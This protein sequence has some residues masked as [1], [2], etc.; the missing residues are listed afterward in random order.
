QM[1]T[2][3]I[4]E[5]KAT[6]VAALPNA[7]DSEILNSGSY[8]LAD[9]GIELE[10]AEK[11]GRKAVDLLT[12]ESADWTPGQSIR[13]Q[14]AKQQVMVAAWDTL[15][16]AIYK[17]GRVDE[18]EGYIRAAWLNGQQHEEGLHLGE[19]QEKQGHD[20]AALK[21]YEMAVENL[22]HDM[23]KDSTKK[24][25]PVAEKLHERVDALRKK[26]TK[27]GRIDA[28]A[29][30]QKLRT[31][32]VGRSAG[33][34]GFVEYAFVLSGGRAVE[35][36][37]GMTQGTELADGDA[38]VRKADLGGRTPPGSSARLLRK[39]T[40]NCHSAECEFIVHP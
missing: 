18:A 38:M 26:G 8:E 37:K 27:S 28:K 5:G 17:E 30:L 14:P 7:N 33:R 9:A 2:G 1:K 23:S 32:P 24:L 35:L 10:A 34:S 31:L 39:G 21:V 12:A 36:Q 4:T 16:W 29:G 15:G 3:K 19:I 11:S 25:D 22:R 6:L 20:E 13:L 40:L